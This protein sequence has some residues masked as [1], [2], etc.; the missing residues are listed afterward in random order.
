MMAHLHHALGALRSQL[1]IAK[2]WWHDHGQAGRNRIKIHAVGILV[3]S[4]GLQ[5]GN[6][7]RRQLQCPLCLV[8]RKLLS[9]DSDEEQA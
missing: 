3:F 7:L 1:R 4:H 5:N 2:P 8:E 9:A 6:P